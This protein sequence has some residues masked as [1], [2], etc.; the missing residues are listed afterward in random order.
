MLGSSVAGDPLRLTVRSG[1]GLHA[2]WHR[3]D[4]GTA[5]RGVFVHAAAFADEMNKSRRMVAQ[6]SRLLATA[7]FAVLRPD[8]TGCGDSD[9]EFGDATWTG[10]VDD[11]LAAAEWAV[12]QPAMDSVPLWFWGHR[13]GALLACAAA[14]RRPHSRLLLWQPVT[15][16]RSQLRQF[17]RLKSAGLRAAG[18]EGVTLDQLQAELKTGRGVDVAGYHVSPALATGLEQARLSPPSQPAPAIWLDV[19]T[20]A[21]A[22]PSAAALAA[23]QA[24]ADAGQDL[25]VVTACGP[26]FWE[27]TEIEDAPALLEATRTACMACLACRPSAE[28]A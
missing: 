28:A 10:W 12:R 11:L 5:V 22:G 2:V 27:T 15:S 9:G 6:Q 23:V 7:G 20:E 16:G 24:W 26:A 17:L 1:H 25:R 13:T 3:P 4:D 18:R 21:G 14:A 8:L 19:S